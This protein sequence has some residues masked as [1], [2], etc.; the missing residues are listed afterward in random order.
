MG[1]M[2]ERFIKALDNRERK[3]LLKVM[4]QDEVVE[5]L[6]LVEGIDQLLE[7]IYG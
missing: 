6:D 2:V 5:L 4:K 7:E 3:N 1:F